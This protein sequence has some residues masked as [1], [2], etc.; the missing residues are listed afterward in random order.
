MQPIKISALDQQNWSWNMILVKYIPFQ[1]KM[2]IQSDTKNRKNT[3][4]LQCDII[5][6]GSFQG[7]PSMQSRVR[8]PG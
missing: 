6:I 8:K 4:A 5:L 7:K 2:L 3:F 1:N